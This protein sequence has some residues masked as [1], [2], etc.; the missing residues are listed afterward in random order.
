MILVRLLP[1]IVITLPLFPAVN[2]LM[3]NDTR[4]VLVL[5]VLRVFP[6]PGNAGS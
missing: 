2:W 1:P 5:V 6:Q 4:T 3:L